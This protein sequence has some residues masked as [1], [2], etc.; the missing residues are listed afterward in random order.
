M[1]FLSRSGE[2]Y[3]A[4]FISPP[5]CSNRLDEYTFEI[6]TKRR[7][8]PR[9]VRF[10]KGRRTRSRT[11]SRIVG[12]TKRSNGRRKRRRR[13]RPVGNIDFVLTNADTRT[14]GWPSTNITP[15]ARLS[16]QFTA[17]AVLLSFVNTIR[18]KERR[19]EG[20]IFLERVWEQ[21]FRISIIYY[22]QVSNINYQGYSR[23]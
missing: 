16:N 20:R 13:R 12:G 2:L 11:R 22:F 14:T 7:L 17:F 23:L 4:L 8:W 19:K 18:T 1:S 21:D 3:P 10:R 15:L 6:S 9:L 5:W